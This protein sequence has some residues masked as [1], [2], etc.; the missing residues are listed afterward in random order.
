M[1]RGASGVA[2]EL[3]LVE[4]W[5]KAFPL[6]KPPQ[7]LDKADARRFPPQYYEGELSTEGCGR[8]ARA[9]S[10]AEWERERIDTGARIYRREAMDVGAHIHLCNVC[11][12]YARTYPPT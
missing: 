3:D 1:A 8:R 6:C 11:S 7:P 5:K 9:L 12:V 10:A 4:P 2:A